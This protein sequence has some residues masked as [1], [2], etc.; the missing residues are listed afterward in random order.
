[1][2]ISRVDTLADYW[3]V[4]RGDLRRLAKKLGCLSHSGNLLLVH[5]FYDRVEEEAARRR[6]E[7]AA[8]QD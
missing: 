4:P 5:L 6:I 8:T 2:P 1:M 7:D 3:G